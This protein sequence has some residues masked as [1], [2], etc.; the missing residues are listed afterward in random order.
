MY[1]CDNIV[2]SNQKGFI[3]H[4]LII[5]NFFCI[6]TTIYYLSLLNILYYPTQELTMLEVKVMQGQISVLIYD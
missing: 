5:K 6:I 4:N 3:T 2:S 1:S